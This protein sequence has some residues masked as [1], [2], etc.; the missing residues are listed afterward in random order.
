MHRLLIPLFACLFMGAPALLR[1][2]ILQEIHYPPFDPHNVPPAQ[3]GADM[4]CGNAGTFTLGP[5]LAESND[6]TLP[7]IFLCHG[8][9]FFV[10]HNGDAD[11]SGD[12]VPGTTPGIAFGFYQCPPSVMGDNLLAIIGSAIP[13]V[14]GDPCILPGATTGLYVTP[15]VP[16][17]GT[18]T[19]FNSGALQ[20]QFNMGQPISL[21]F[22]PIT[23]DS[24]ANGGG[25]EEPQPGFPPGPCVNVNTAAAFNVVYLN[26]ITTNGIDSM[27]VG[28]DCLGQFTIRGGFPQYDQLLN[29][30]A[31][32]TI[33]IF[34]ESD[35]SVKAIVHTSKLTYFANVIFSVPQPGFYTVVVEDG[36][37][38][39]ATFRVNMNGCNASD[40]LGLIFP[41]TIVPPGNQICVAVT[42]ENFTIFSG[43]FSV[44]WDESVLQYTGLQNANPAI[45]SIFGPANLNE[46]EVA[47]GLL[48]AQ[49][50][51]N[52]NP[53][54]ITIPDG[55]TLFEICFTAVG[56]LGD[57]SGLIVTNDPTGVALEDETGQEIALS[58]DTGQV[59]IAF[60][61]LSF[62][63]EVV[64]TTCLGEA[65]LNIIPSGGV[66]PYQIIVEEINGPTYSTD[67]NTIINTGGGIFEVQN[68]IGSTDNTAVTYNICV[69]DNNGLGATQCTTLVVNI[70]SLGAQLDF[71]QQPTCNGDSDGIVNAV[72]LF[73]GAIVPN[74]GPNFTF[75]WS[76]ANVPDPTGPSQNNVK[77][78]PFTVTVTD[79]NTGCSFFASG[80]LP[81][82]T[83]ISA[84]SVTQIPAACSGICNGVITYEAEGGTPFAGMVYQYAW[85]NIT[86]GL[87]AGTGTGNPIV[88]N[89]ACGGDYRITLT[90]AN[91]CVFVDSVTLN[92][93]RDITIEPVGQIQNVLCNGGSTGA[94]SVTVMESPPSGNPFTFFWTPPTAGAMQMDNT[95]SSTYSKLPAGSYTV[96]AVD[97]LGCQATNTFD[98]A[99][100]PLL[101]LDTL[102]G[103][104]GIEQPGCDLPNSGSIC[105]FTSGGSGGPNTFVYTWSN[106]GANNS[107]CQNGLS[108][109]NYGITVTDVNGCQDSLQIA[110][111][112]PQPPTITAVDSTG[113]GCGDDGSLSVTAPGGFLFIWTDINGVVID[114]TAAIDSLVGGS[115][116]IHIFDEKG[117]ETIDTFTLMP[118][119]P[120]SFSDTTLI[121]PSCFGFADGQI[122]IGVQDGQPPYVMYTWNPTQPNQ[123]VIFNLEAGLHE[124]TVTDN[125][126]CELI[127]A[128]TLSQPPEIAITFA[129][130]PTIIGRVSC[131]GIC[132]GDAA[133]V[134]VYNSTPQTQG[135]FSFL[136]EDGSTDSLRTD[137][138]AGFNSVTVTDGAACFS[139]GSV[140]ITTPP[141]I[142]FSA[143]TTT[144]TNCFG[145]STGTA[146]ITAT[147]GNGGPYTYQ[148]NIP[149]ATTSSITGLPFGVYT[150]TI[151]DNSE[152]TNSIDTINIGQPEEMQLMTSAED[153]NCFGGSNGQATVEVMGGVSP[154][155]YLWQNAAGVNVG[156]ANMAEMLN[157]G[158]YDVTVTD[159]NGCTT[160]GSEVITDPDGVD[161]SYEDLEPLICNGDETI[162]NIAS[163]SG[164]SGGP[165]RFSV[166]FGAVLD[167]N[168]PVSIGGGVHYITYYDAKDCAIT[169]S[170][171]VLEP[172]P[173]TVTFD[174]DLI[175]IEL[176]ATADLEPIITGAA[177]IGS[178]TWT[179][180]LF[181]LYADTLNA[182]A[183]TFTNLTYTLTVQD[184]FGCSGSGSVV[185]NVDPNRN[186][187]VPNI[188]APNNPTGLNDHFNVNAGLG[189]ELVNFM[190]V[191]DRWG[192]LMYQREKFI[193]D[194]DNL[195]EG[196]DGRFNGDFVNPGVFIY[197]VEVKFLDGRVLLY[198][199]DVT[200]VR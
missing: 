160:V 191:Y 185:V 83:P 82:P 135:N 156:N 68:T 108:V 9:T 138:C 61:P 116:I 153:P 51:N 87:P 165:Y 118:V 56:Q 181:L 72:V 145:D 182:V 175:E 60:L 46:L 21:F 163:I 195:G 184:T 196:W 189:V 132:D 5:F 44:E 75:A 41:D 137:L 33:N 57:C 93:A 55:E 69:Q 141:E 197:L 179:N 130:S 42:V 25:F 15:A 71:A 149:G 23:V 63:Y 4:M 102:G 199:G 117:C 59:C 89:N 151:T 120:M 81:Q 74:P 96:V 12:P 98:I 14:L 170:I 10:K 58:V 7:T 88:L 92:N 126:G 110:L 164:G 134:V 167:P 183:Y 8:D 6:T 105:L 152:C 140:E 157:A 85:T 104:G 11:L 188:F 180:P 50:F 139:I 37:S 3:H 158:T 178:F 127:G 77:A 168:F 174:P 35:P 1:A 45:D 125:V 173:I 194:N 133:P 112:T 20:T 29:G 70:P 43:T 17:G 62:T 66:A 147:G 84:Q 131:F 129:L 144:P 73:G 76:P 30:D 155:T 100:P 52:P 54:V 198:R 192:E 103:I 47:N 171:F 49:V 36:K 32:Y 124:V 107:N 22:A 67:N 99:E 13:P 97:N 136:W 154:Y 90:D 18:T 31:E 200:V 80:A 106:P 162:L 16:N 176:G 148:W 28:N 101:V 53:S 186:V 26:E 119:T 19:F 91:G 190:R 146:S 38:C 161:G 169:D 177:V 113:V 142:T 123:S 65:T 48:G 40:N 109:G 187:Y 39:P 193:P 111:L 64:D 86:T 24:F 114:S 143:L 115:Y 27:Y 128:F 2:Q 150:V 94:I 95:P 79:T 159:A 122:A 121:E 34:L 166:D 78:G 172:A